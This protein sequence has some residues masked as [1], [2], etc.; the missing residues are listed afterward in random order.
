[1]TARMTTYAWIVL[2]AIT[3]ASWWLAPGH[4]HRSAV[5]SVPITVAVIV[6]GFIKGRLI[7]RCFMEVHA[8]PRWLK[9]FTDAWLVTVW[10]GV[11]AI[12]LS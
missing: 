2:S 10:A 3:L 6:L 12:Y 4:A 5:A 11:L 8:A 9:V 1:M 7:I